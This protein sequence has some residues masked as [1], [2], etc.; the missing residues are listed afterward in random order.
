MVLHFILPKRCTTHNSNLQED[1]LDHH[2]DYRVFLKRCK[3]PWNLQLLQSPI[4]HIGFDGKISKIYF[5]A[6][7]LHLEQ[8]YFLRQMGEVAGLEWFL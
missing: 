6:T 1:K 2:T 5:D 4:Y 3:N 7:E 8:T